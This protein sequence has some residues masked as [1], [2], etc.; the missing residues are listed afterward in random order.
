MVE[1]DVQV[2][3]ATETGDPSGT[4]WTEAGDIDHRGHDAALRLAEYIEGDVERIADRVRELLDVGWQR[5]E[6]ATDHGWLLVPGGLPKVDLPAAATAIKKGRCARLKDGANVAVPTV[7]WYWDPDVRIALAPGISCFEA[8]KLYEHGGV[9]LQECVVPRLRVTAGQAVRPTGGPEITRV[10]WL[11]LLCRIEFAGVRPG[12]RVD[13]RGLPA[14]PST[15]V[16]ERAKE[17]TGEGRISLIVPDE[18][19]EGEDAYVVVLG[20]EDELLG[21]A[22]VII[23]QNQ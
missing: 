17:T 15:S 9:S 4:A 16:A 19:H 11:G 6:V 10:R 8:G 1:R 20:A 12:A 23:G 14:D 2:L 13:I 5:V 18:E 21:Q 3:S 22:P 7:P